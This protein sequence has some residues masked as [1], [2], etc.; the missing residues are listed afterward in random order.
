MALT[1]DRWARGK[2]VTL[3]P[4]AYAVRIETA[5]QRSTNFATGVTWRGVATGETLTEQARV[6]VLAGGAV[7]TPRLWLNSG[8]SDPHDRVGRGHEQHY[9]AYGLQLV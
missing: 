8:R 6:V 2:A 4:D 9:T 3:V 7:E 1:A 5:T